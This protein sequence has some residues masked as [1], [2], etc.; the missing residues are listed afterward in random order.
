MDWVH[1]PFGEMKS[2][3]RELLSKEKEASYQSGRQSV[4]DEIKHDQQKLLDGFSHP[5]DCEE[6][7]KLKAISNDK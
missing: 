1:P 7:G 2:F 6:C 5:K 3:I 4:I